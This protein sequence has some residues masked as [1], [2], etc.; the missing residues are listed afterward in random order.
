MIAAQ[1]FIAAAQARGFGLWTGV[2]CSF[3]QPLINGVINDETLTYVGAA[4]EGDA[5]AIAAGAYIGGISSVVMM[6]NSGL[7]NAVNPLTSL[8]HTHQ[9]PCLL[10][11][12]LRGD[13]EGSTDE[14]QHGLMGRITQAML[15]LMEIPWAWF[16]RDEHDIGPS[17]DAAVQHMES[18]GRPY[19]LVMRKGSVA[20]CPAPALPLLQAPPRPS[21]FASP[22]ITPVVSRRQ[23]LE[24]VQDATTEFDLLVATTGYSSR[25]LYALGDRANQLYLVGAMG[26]ASS[27][28]LGLALACPERRVIVLDGDGA[29]LMRM[30]AMATL[31]FQCPPNVLHLLLD[32]GMHESTGGQG[33]ISH[34]LNWSGM[35][36]CAGYA[37]YLDVARPEQLFELLSRP[38]VGASFVRAYLV[39][40]V[41]GDLPRP[42]ISPAEV[43][44]R[45]RV[46][47]EGLSPLQP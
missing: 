37:Q 34:A 4:N 26:C 14:P 2:P 39:P 23:M 5:V 8:L 18:S 41:P 40:G 6:Q 42:T 12:T 28:G 22:E 3:L 1:S 33:T 24:A 11:V 20:D 36:A 17:L 44:Q 21:L 47:V 13:P 7:G 19:C 25:E 10:I 46:H 35:A 29:L 16:P 27:V 43:T 30:G 31:G 38:L 32:N 15:D 45:L 9:I